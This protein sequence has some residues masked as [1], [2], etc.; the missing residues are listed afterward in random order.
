MEGVSPSC[1]SPP[2]PPQFLPGL[3]TQ[4]PT[5]SPTWVPRGLSTLVFSQSCFTQ[6]D[7]PFPFPDRAPMLGKLLPTPSYLG[8]PGPMLQMRKLRPREVAR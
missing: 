5:P 2:P 8:I 4:A 1:Q 3:Q 6:S 7:Q